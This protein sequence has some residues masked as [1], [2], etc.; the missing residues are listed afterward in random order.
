VHIFL[1]IVDPN[2]NFVVCTDVC[3]EGLVGVLA[4]NGYV[5]SYEYINLKENER[6]YAMHDLKLVTIVNTLNI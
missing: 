4:E 1:N 5:N 2:E 3:K 6:N